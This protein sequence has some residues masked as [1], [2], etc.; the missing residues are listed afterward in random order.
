MKQA[1]QLTFRHMDSS[2]ALEEEIRRRAA[3]LETFHSSLIGCQV[4]VEAS[5]HRHHQG[6]LYHARISLTVPG[7]EI[8]VSRDPDQHHAYEDVYVAVGDAFDAA[9]RQLE[10]LTR[11]LRGDVKQHET[12]PHGRIVEL[13]PAEDFGRIETQDGRLVYFH[14]NSVINASFDRL[15]E[16]DE[17]RFDETHGDKG[18]QASTVRVIGKH[19]LHG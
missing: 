1:L 2:P 5:H 16:G 12:P 18:P 7:H 11:K 14:R 13:V 17:V 9:G 4:V 10:D 15:A 3:K 8:V 6:N 19:H